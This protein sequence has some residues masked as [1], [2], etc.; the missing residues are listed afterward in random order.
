MGIDLTH[1]QTTSA[2]ETER[3]PRWRVWTIRIWYALLGVWTLAM[4]HSVVSLALG[5]A[6]PGERFGSG[7]V[8]AW[9]LLAVGG[10]FG[11]CWTGGRSV[12]AFQSLVV[13]WV[14]WLGSERLYAV[15]PPDE[16]PVAS[17]IT[18]VI[19]WLLPLALLR[20]H[21]RQL[22]HLDLR[23][24]AILLPLAL[25]A[26]VPLSIYAVRQGG[27]VTELTGPAKFYY[28]ACGLGAVLAVQAIYASL[29]PRRSRWLPR[30]VALA[31][32]W[33]GLLAV[34]WPHDL[35]SPGRAWGAV[36]I[37]WAL[38]FAAAAEVETRRD[39]EQDRL[40]T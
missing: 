36:L 18:T 30:F 1:E 14:G 34:I 7:A 3:W 12:V 32:A 22:L 26:A 4:S 35:T 29:R 38:L 17:A 23:P 21:R 19:L 6:G 15:A 16:T 13:G 40:P 5:Q 24:S 25:V 27:L 9:K 20:P 11:I 33:I 28:S 2:A 10:V 8:T 39:P 37:C 31:A